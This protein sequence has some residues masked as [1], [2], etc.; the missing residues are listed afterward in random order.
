MKIG[1]E[2]QRLFRPKKHGMDRVALEL[3]RNL[4][5]IDLENEYYVFVRS[6]EDTAV[7]KETRNFKIIQLEG[8]SYPYWEQ[9]V[10]PK[11]AKKHGCQMLHCTSNTAPYFP[12]M[13]LVTTLHDIIYLENNYVSTLA[14]SASLYQKFGNVYR[15][16][17]IPGIVKKSQKIITVSHYEKNRI[18]SYFGINGD[19]RLRAVHNGVSEHF[20]PVTD[21]HELKR[22]KDIR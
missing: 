22:V 6:D 12:G 8:H 17:I 20:R 2:G 9:I 21:K 19:A 10:L 11:A 5:E 7:L 14:G 13:P 3:I 15:K 16:L 18:G 4:Q 1:I